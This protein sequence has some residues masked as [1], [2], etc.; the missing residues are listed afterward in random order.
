MSSAAQPA[1]SVSKLECEISVGGKGTARV[2]LFR[3]LAPI[4]VNSLLRTLPFDSR[5]SVQPAMVSLFTELRIGV[6]K[7]RAQFARGDVAFL[8]SG[9]LVCIFIG[10]ARSD[11][12]LNPVGKVESGIEHFDSVRPGDVVRMSAPKQ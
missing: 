9:G 6:E 7:P 1:G 8:P 4:T 11:R 3:H 5:V 2:S 12:P 10:S